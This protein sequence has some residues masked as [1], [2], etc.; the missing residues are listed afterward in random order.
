MDAAFASDIDD[1]PMMAAPTCASFIGNVD[2]Y[3][4]VD[5]DGQRCDHHILTQTA[6]AASVNLERSLPS[7]TLQ[8]CAMKCMSPTKSC[9]LNNVIVAQRKPNMKL[10]QHKIASFECLVDT[11]D[12][13][14][15]G[16]CSK[17]PSQVT[18]PSLDSTT[19]H[20]GLMARNTSAIP[21]TRRNVTLEAIC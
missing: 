1:S 5:A 8:R 12:R 13:Q 2:C 21:N 16:M 10:M 7:Q 15:V 11:N 19:V 18:I 4:Q 20:R 6:L 9:T 3:L 14:V 17:F